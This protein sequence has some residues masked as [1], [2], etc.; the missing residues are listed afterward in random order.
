MVDLNWSNALFCCNHA[1]GPYFCNN[2]RFT[3]RLCWCSSCK[4]VGG[5]VVC[6]G[7]WVCGCVVL[8]RLAV[9]PDVGGR[10]VRQ[11]GG[12]ARRESQRRP[13]DLSR[14]AGTAPLLSHFSLSPPPPSPAHLCPRVVDGRLPCT[15]VPP[16][17]LR[18]LRHLVSRE[19]E[20]GH[21][22]LC[23][24]APDLALVEIGRRE[25]ACGRGCGG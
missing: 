3:S 11:K 12:S 22:L 10:L 13:V 18:R 1:C 20:L 4:R 6:A 8:G 25:R 19:V 2:S 14:L 15:G 9:R 16:E 7:A 17:L 21:R 5:W 23:L 24:H